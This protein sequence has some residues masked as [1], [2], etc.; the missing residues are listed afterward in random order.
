MAKG[1]PRLQARFKPTGYVLD[2]TPDKNRQTFHGSVIISGHNTHRPSHRLV[3][4][5]Q[6]LKITSV[7]VT[8]HDR[9]G[10][11]VMTVNR[12]NLHRGYDEVRIHTEEILY[13][14]HYTV[15]MDFKGR[16]T[17]PMNGLYPCFFTH[18]GDDKQLLA[19]QFESH[20]AREVFPC[21]DE[22]A[23][24]ATFDLTIRS[25]PGETVL[26]NMPVKVQ[27]EDGELRATTFETTPHMSPYLLAFV[28]GELEHKQA[29]TKAGVTV[30]AYAT[31]DNVQ[32]VDFAL[33]IAVKMLDFYNDYFAIPY[34]LPKCDLVAL[35][36]FAAGA[37]ENW[38]LVTF[39]EQG[40]LL[41]PN[42][43]S[44]QGQQYIA[45]VVGHE[46]AHQW[47]GNLVTMR[48]WTDLWLN[49]GFASWIEYLAV[50]TL[51][52]EWQMWTQFL[53]DEQLPAMKTDALEHSHPVIVPVD[54]P[55]DIR[56]IFDIISYGKGASIILMLHEY[57][58]KDFFRDGLRLYLDTYKYKNTSTD[59]LWDA[60]Q[61]VS[62]KPVKAFMHAWTEKDGYP[63]VLADVQDRQVELSQ[64]RFYSNPKH[65]PEK[66]TTRWPIPLQTHAT[67]LPTT[68]EETRL[69]FVMHDPSNLKFNRG[70]SG[71]YRLAYNASHL[72]R[73][74]E[75]VQRGKLVA[76]D[77]LGVLN[78]SFEAAKAGYLPTTDALSLLEHYENE[79][80][81][82]VWDIIAGNLASIRLIMDDDDLRELMKPFVRQ[83]V[84]KELKKVGW[85]VKDTD[86]H[87]TRLL[88]PTIL[89]MA[90]LADEPPVVKK[91]LALFKTMD[92]PEDIAPDLRATASRIHFRAGSVNPDIRGVVYG[93]AARHGS[94]REF[95]KLLAMHNHTPSSEERVNL[96]AALTSFKQPALIDQ[97]LALITSDSVRLQDVLYWAVYSFINR[98]AKHQT[99]EW[100]TTHWHWLE[101]NFTNDPSFYRFPIY[102]A[103]AF[104][105]AS[106][107]ATFTDFF[108]RVNSRGMKRAV[109]QGIDMIEWQAAWKKRD[110][111]LIK[112]Y[113][114]SKADPPQ[115]P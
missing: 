4:H 73:L 27:T 33:D 22:P 20:H 1:V 98:H 36:D 12:V 23:A 85:K 6:G 57:L 81:A 13:P 46:L 113:F 19:T 71:F 21:I 115:K 92:H 60:L 99:W 34:P 94:H 38:G 65:P 106:F 110:L 51:F 63:L 44:R 5:Q 69:N 104:S 52:P 30:R 70:Q 28:I 54:N 109:K 32:F 83:L 67:N 25:L 103:G 74:G 37:M 62:D 39:R 108:A 114:K 35:P 24:K 82:A 79:D 2:I 91:A 10:D 7:H 58:G 11:Q 84:T 72:H 45:M 68:F 29:R 105:D 64:Q 86:S 100:M 50:D 101:E 8:R 95:K 107:V 31:A 48:W 40:L 80:N 87:F 102:A 14:G 26:S 89:S 9:K 59:D 18:N 42:N 88:R 49:E 16:I 17:R 43:T 77:R 112:A 66:S 53:V 15:R 56:T 55:A 96:A 61:T 97:A 78:D 75:L 93:T 90:A 3:F 47:F 41:D 111:A 76:V